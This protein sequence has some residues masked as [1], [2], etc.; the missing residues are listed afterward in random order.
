MFE[1][2][3]S[4]RYLVI[5]D[6]IVK[7]TLSKMFIVLFC[8][9]FM[10]VGAV[11]L[12]GTLRSGFNLFGLVWGGMFFFIPLFIM[13]TRFRQ[14]SRF[15]KMTYHWY[16]QTHPEH[17][18]DQGV[19]CFACGHHRVQVR[20]LLNRTYHREHFCAQCGKTLYYSPE[21]S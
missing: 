6:A 9:L 14:L 4:C 17:A 10:A 8:S 15:Q 20:A 18:K 3:H 11:A 1:A 2:V 19:S 7:Y 13:V 16:R 21:Q 12:F 5:G